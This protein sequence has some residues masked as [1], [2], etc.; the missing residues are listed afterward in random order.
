M[1]NS[2][3]PIRPD[4]PHPSEEQLLAFLDSE[5]PAPVLGEI[6]CHLDECPACRLEFTAMQQALHSVQEVWNAQVA[7]E[8]ASN[9]DHLRQF[10]ARLAQH[11]DA[12]TSIRSR[13]FAGFRDRKRSFAWRPS[14]LLRYRIP[15]LASVV[16]IALVIATTLALFESTASAEVLLARSVNKENFQAQG[17]APV[18][19]SVLQFE[20]VDTASGSARPLGNYTLLKDTS[21]G[22]AQVS[23]NF[24]SG[25]HGEWGAHSK[26]ML[27]Q[28]AG[29]A[30]GSSSIFDP[31][32]LHYMQATDF[33]PDAS[34]SE[35]R[36]LVTG[37]GTEKTLVQKGI[38]AYGLDYLFGSSH[39]SGIRNAVLWVKKD[40][41]D[42][43]QLSIF[44]ANAKEYRFTRETQSHEQ[45][46]PDVAGILSG[47]QPTL[48]SETA[49]SA[50]VP[51]TVVPLKYAKSLASS[52]E[53]HAVEVLHRLGACLG[54]EVYVYPM[55]N[56]TVLVQ[57][58][59]DTANRRQALLSSLSQAGPDVHPEIYTPAQLRPGVS[60][61]ES[62]YDEAL[63]HGRSQNGAL[64]VQSSDLSNWQSAFHDELVSSY[65]AS[66][67]NQ[68]EAEAE[69]AA[70]SNKLVG[71]ARKLLLH[72][73]ALQRLQ[74]EFSPNRTIQLST[75]DLQTIS[76]LE[77]EH[78]Q[79]IRETASHEINL[80]SRLT[81]ANPPTADE[82]HP[83][84]S[85]ASPS[86]STLQLAQEEERL[87][88]AL[89][90][91][92][93]QPAKKKEDLARL[94]EVLDSLER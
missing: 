60:V 93:Q 25:A 8:S 45:R 36:K 85:P 51:A 18:S 1:T 22:Q 10:R 54:E 19:R 68:E 57:G 80:L 3:D 83:K 40:S 26:D 73:W 66:G 23:V 77:D 43:F 33:F 13:A 41:Y 32:L 70:F 24:A 78:R 86:P 92:S 81:Q 50:P 56:G 44:T 65:A 76:A 28:L 62:P 48:N 91:V 16:A 71:L 72:S 69:A 64:A 11:A 53:L 46:T 84:S 52:N 7:A 38:N 34:A 20:L 31:A 39:P 74:D 67:K 27:G 87:I 63:A 9:L 88:R 58:L 37:R 35:F 90:T 4:S 17:T 49:S 59:V 47:T 61:L 55:S 75:P 79:A 15:I 12:L 6:K 89:F 14:F 82:I 94:L 42:P 29:K 21:S 2:S 30:F 5:L